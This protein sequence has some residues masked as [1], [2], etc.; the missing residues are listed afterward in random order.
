MRRFFRKA[1]RVLVIGLDCASPDLIFNEFRQDLPVLSS[2]MR[3]GTW[4][5][6][7]SSIPCI[8]VPAWASMLSSRDPGV[9]GVYGF[10][11]RKDRS[12]A[13]MVTADGS[14]IKHRRV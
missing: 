12:Y 14:A 6:L 1:S 13:H 4:G 11:N 2:L 7:R 3:H 10:R 5:I 8:T 9:L